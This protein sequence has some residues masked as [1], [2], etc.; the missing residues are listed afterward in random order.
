MLAHLDLDAFFAA[1]EELENPELKG[2]PVVVAGDPKGRGVVAT[3]NY[4]ARRY[5]IRSAMSAAEA[6]RRCPEAV[7]VRP[8]KGLYGRYSRQVWEIVRELV[9]VVERVGLDE[10][11]LDLG[12]EDVEKAT[13]LAR[14]VQEEIVTWTTLS[15]SLGV[16][17]TKV[18]AKVAS[19]QQKPY[20]LVVVA[21]G[22]EATFLAPFPVRL[23]P[24]VGPKA[25]AR[26]KAAGVA[27]VGQLAA[28]SDAELAELWR[29]RVGPL[30]R[31]RARGVDPRPVGEERK[32][33]SYSSEETFATDVDDRARLDAELERMSEELCVRLV[34]ADRA[35]RTVVVK[36]RYPDFT[37][38]T[39]QL[40]LK[41]GTDAPAVVLA[42][43]RIL[44]ER[45]LEE[46][47]EPLR[48]LGLAVSG[49]V[50]QWQLRL[51]VEAAA[52]RDAVQPER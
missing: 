38:R 52:E 30:L 29:G 46:R 20:G 3:A 1:V 48:L 21:P 28:L 25:E 5:G 44:L 23:L 31:D 7:F 33:V 4:E 34:R 11:Y 43:A 40:T 47:D 42:S 26:L 6:L 24:G 2:K 14:R 22:D 8:S 10:G 18:V 19:D 37:T 41:N 50:D 16:A 45:A 39:R 9:P 12:T 35:A 36:L 49:F 17:T 27:T 51:E 32:S 13:S 15:S